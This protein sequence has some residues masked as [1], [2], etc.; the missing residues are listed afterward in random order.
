MKT[1]TTWYEKP[2]ENLMRVLNENYTHVIETRRDFGKDKN[3]TIYIW[4]NVW[5]LDC[6]GH[7]SL[8]CTLYEPSMRYSIY[9]CIGK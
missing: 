4:F 6:E 2:E 8:L 1:K 9:R 7:I 5:P 3:K